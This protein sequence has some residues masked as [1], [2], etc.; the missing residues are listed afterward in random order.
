MKRVGSLSSLKMEASCSSETS[1]DLTTPR[2]IPE[3][4][5]YSVC[6]MIASVPTEVRTDGLVRALPRDACVCGGSDL[7]PH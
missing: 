5:S 2:Y 6:V 4:R 7:A 3:D 1:V